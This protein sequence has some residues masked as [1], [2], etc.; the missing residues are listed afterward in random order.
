[1]K[2]EHKCGEC[3]HFSRF[4]NLPFYYCRMYRYYPIQYYE[5]QAYTYQREIIIEETHYIVNHNQKSCDKFEK[6]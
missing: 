2:R 1:M 3:R 5:K 6:R 4:I